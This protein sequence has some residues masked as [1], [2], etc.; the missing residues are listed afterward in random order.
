MFKTTA[1]LMGGLLLIC[2]TR[3][4]AQ[5][6]IAVPERPVTT[7]Q[8]NDS[9]QISY[10]RPKAYS[11][12]TNIPCDWAQAGKMA[13]SKKGLIT[14]S[15]VT[16]TT[17]LCLSVDRP[18]M[19]AVQRFGHWAGI[20]GERKFKTGIGF[21]LG[22][23]QVNM[24]DLPQN[25][26]STLYFIGEGWP[27]ILLTAGVLT[28]GLITN[29]NR[30]ILTASQFAESYLAMGVTVQVL[31][32]L[33]GRQSPFVAT[34]RTGEWANGTGCL[35]LPIISLMFPNTMHFL[36]DIWLQPWL[37]LRFM[38]KTIP[39]ISLSARWVTA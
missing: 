26:N 21:K 14:L 25:L 11:F 35:L 37:P 36:R 27:S 20:S 3:T 29:D 1:C 22:G 4:F 8:I 16:V 38:P 5:D 9:N 2:N 33:T 7:V 18:A 34:S 39:S 28:K 10:E 24:L 32:R 17:L 31:K 15:A 30:A 13:I 12:L 19:D 23:I 6:S